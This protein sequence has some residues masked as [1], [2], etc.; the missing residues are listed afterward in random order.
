MIADANEHFEKWVNSE[1][2]RQ[3]VSVL[4]P[5]DKVTLSIFYAPS[6]RGTGYVVLP[7]KISITSEY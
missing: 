1:T 3:T 2:K 5:I 7:L 4:K 6:N